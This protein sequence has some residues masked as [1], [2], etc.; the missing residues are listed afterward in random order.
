[1]DAAAFARRYVTTL[2]L[3]PFTITTVAALVL[4]RLPVALWGFPL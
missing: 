3:G 2:A 4:G 1:V